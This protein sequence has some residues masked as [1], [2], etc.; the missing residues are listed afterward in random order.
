M[1]VQK[2]NISEQCSVSDPAKKGALRGEVSTVRTFDCAVLDSH[3]WDNILRQS[4]KN[5]IAAHIYNIYSFKYISWYTK[6]TVLHVSKYIRESP[7]KPRGHFNFFVVQLTLT[8][9]T[10]FIAYVSG[11]EVLPA[12]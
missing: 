8:D 5:I 2:V 10:A 9:E 1:R 6:T 3:C 4:V 7:Q 12:H 11:V